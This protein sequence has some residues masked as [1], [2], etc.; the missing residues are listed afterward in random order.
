MSN[1]NPGVHAIFITDIIRKGSYVIYNTNSE[2]LIKNAFNLN[3]IKEGIFIPNILSRKKQII[4]P[5][6]EIMETM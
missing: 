1:K 5:I 6:M 4:P 2:E 3:S